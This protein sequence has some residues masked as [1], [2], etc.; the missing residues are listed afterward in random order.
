MSDTHVS[1]IRHPFSERLKATTGRNSFRVSVEI[2]QEETMA[3]RWY[4]GGGVKNQEVD[5]DQVEAK[6]CV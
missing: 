6:R 3:T 5:F 4:Q 1:G 2:S